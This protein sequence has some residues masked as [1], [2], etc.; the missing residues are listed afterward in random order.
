MDQSYNNIK[1]TCCINQFQKLFF[2]KLEPFYLA[3]VDNDVRVLV[4]TYLRCL[5]MCEPPLSR[6]IVRNGYSNS[7]EVNDVFVILKDCMNDIHVSSSYF[8]V[9]L[10]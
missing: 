8:G 4:L 1:L 3:N 5:R 9:H 7:N 6:K 10:L 2:S